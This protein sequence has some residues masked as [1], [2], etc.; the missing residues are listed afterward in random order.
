MAIHKTRSSV[1]RFGLFALLILQAGLRPF[2]ALRAFA[3]RLA[4]DD[5]RIGQRFRGGR[6]IVVLD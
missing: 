3:R 2:N 6:R 1:M 5:Q 4:R